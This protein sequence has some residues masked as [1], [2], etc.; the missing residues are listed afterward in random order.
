MG[1]WSR[2][3]TIMGGHGPLKTVASATTTNVPDTVS[4]FYISGSAT[5][6]SLV[7]TPSLRTRHVTVIG[8]SGASVTF[9]NTTGST[10]ANQMDLGGANIVLS[11]KDVLRLICNE[12]GVWQLAGITYNN[13]VTHSL[14]S[15]TTTT[16]PDSSNV[17]VVTGTA[18][19]T[20][21]TGTTNAGYRRVLFIGGASAGV[22]F[23]NTDSPATGQMWLG[24][25]NRLLREQQTIELVLQPTGE[26]FIVSSTTG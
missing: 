7:C 5:I 13:A 19:I 20:T 17:F 25:A 14:A 8:A 4:A 2:N 6:T 26:W 16:V 1:I 21:L 12:N 15:A 10:T 22:V 3:K 23:T 9:T 18:T 11:A 24:G